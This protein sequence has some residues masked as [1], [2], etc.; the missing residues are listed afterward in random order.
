MGQCELANG[1][2]FILEET[3]SPRHRV[4]TGGPV[5][6]SCMGWKRARKSFAGPPLRCRAMPYAS[7]RLLR[8][9]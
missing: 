1:T 2:E 6:F 3:G 5:V 4:N 9:A 8:M 7:I